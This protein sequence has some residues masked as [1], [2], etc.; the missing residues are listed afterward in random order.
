[1]IKK[2][3]VIIGCG[4]T[5]EIIADIFETN[6][7]YQIIAYSAEK[8]YAPKSFNGK[9]VLHFENI[10]HE[11]AQ[12]KCDFFVAI[13]ETSLNQL[14]YR[15][16]I[17]A[18]KKGY[19]PAK[20]IHPKA[21]ISKTS[22]IG[23]HCFISENVVI[24]AHCIIGN[25]VIVLPNSYLGHHTFISDH[26]FICAGVNISGFCSI[27]EFSFLG[28]GSSISNCI[29]IGRK[30]VV[31]IGSACSLELPDNSVIA[32]KHDIIRHN[33]ELIFDNWHNKVSEKAKKILKK[34]DNDHDK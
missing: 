18:I 13:G 3:L 9:V 10:E 11:L 21:S 12:D 23:E 22:I 5:A 2:N 4:G 29:S 19:K 15:F 20:F 17:E 34:A 24:H 28:A 7:D 31:G 27:G 32:K 25:N 6:S 14:R 8:K 33:S 1:M 30:C 26:V 16:Y